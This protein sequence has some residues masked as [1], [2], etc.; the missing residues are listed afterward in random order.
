MGLC[1]LVI[2]CLQ[3]RQH[4]QRK[5]QT[6]YLRLAV[7]GSLWFQS[8]PFVTWVCSNAVPFYLR[9]WTVGTWGAAL[10]C[11]SIALLSWLVTTQNSSFDKY[12]KDLPQ[13]SCISMGNSDWKVGNNDWKVGNTK[14]R[15]D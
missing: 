12:A 3:T 13:M 15:L 6:F 7:I 11:S 4:C 10:H 1:C 5:Q 9:H 8:L 2:S 14:I